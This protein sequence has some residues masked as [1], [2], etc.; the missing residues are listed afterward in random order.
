MDN[1]GTSLGLYLLKTE[2]I[3][4]GGR[5]N[6]FTICTLVVRHGEVQN[7]KMPSAAV[8]QQENQCIESSIP[9]VV[10]VPFHTHAEPKISLPTLSSKSMPTLFTRWDFSQANRFCKPLTALSSKHATRL[11]RFNVVLLWNFTFVLVLVPVKTA[12][13]YFNVMVRFHPV[14]IILM[15]EWCTWWLSWFSVLFSMFCVC[16]AW[17]WLF[18][19]EFMCFVGVW[20]IPS[21]YMHDFWIHFTSM[22]TAK[23]NWVAMDLLFG[24]FDKVALLKVLEK[25]NIIISTEVNHAKAASAKSMCT[26]IFWSRWGSIWDVLGC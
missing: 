7:L 21:P 10:C 19:N 2:I 1:T 17:I 4:R 24:W 22:V 13:L 8:L 14:L 26:S 3:F 12:F 23:V 16:S 5:N 20:E 15:W 9:L 6:I 25:V 11:I 18:I